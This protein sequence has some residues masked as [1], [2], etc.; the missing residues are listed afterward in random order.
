MAYL[1]ANGILHRNNKPD[2]VIVFVLD[3]VTTVNGMLTDFWSSRNV[4]MLMT[5]MTFT[6]G[7]RTPTYTTPEVLNKEKYKKAADVFLLAVMLFECDTWGEAYP[8]A[9]F[10]F[11]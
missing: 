7:V 2:N 3:E 5:H 10:K 6:D 8:R 1:H 9:L 11:S 4:N